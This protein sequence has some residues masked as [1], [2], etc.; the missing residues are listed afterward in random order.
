MQKT[1]SNPFSLG[2]ISSFFYAGKSHSLDPTDNMVELINRQTHPNKFRFE[3]RRKRKQ[4]PPSAAATQV[5][6][7]AERADIVEREKNISMV[8]HMHSLEDRNRELRREMDS[9][10]LQVLK[11]EEL[12]EKLASLQKSHSSLSE[13]YQEERG[14]NKRMIKQLQDR[15]DKVQ[16][17]KRKTEEQLLLSGAA[18]FESGMSKETKSLLDGIQA[19]YSEE[20]SQLVSENRIK[21]K[22]LQDMRARRIALVS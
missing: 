19:K 6:E 4:P 13:K 3:L 20:V 9:L 22:T 21:D 11:Q 2:K 12:R 14:A 17:D 8:S 10:Q 15:L 18:S 16:L 7:E 5:S 1:F